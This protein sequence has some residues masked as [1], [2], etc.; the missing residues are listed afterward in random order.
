MISFI[1]FSSVPYF[2]YP[3]IDTKYKHGPV[4]L[5]PLLYS[6]QSLWSLDSFNLK[7]SGIQSIA[8]VVNV[9][10]SQSTIFYF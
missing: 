10:S 2:F 6:Y 1:A 4:S 3:K 7:R 5:Y 8:L 9:N